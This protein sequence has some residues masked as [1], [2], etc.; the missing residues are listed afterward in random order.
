MVRLSNLILGQH[1]Q[2]YQSAK[3]NY[4]P[5]ESDPKMM[6]LALANASSN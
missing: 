5:F 6:K 3:P 2:L 4:R 1:Y